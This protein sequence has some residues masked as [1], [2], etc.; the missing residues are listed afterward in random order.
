M[1]GFVS[2]WISP[3]FSTSFNQCFLAHTI[4]QMTRYR[5]ESERQKSEPTPLLFCLLQKLGR[6]KLKLKRL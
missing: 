6:I 1:I 2:G 3:P 5:V 4:Y